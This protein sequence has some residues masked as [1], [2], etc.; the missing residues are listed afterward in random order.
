LHEQLYANEACAVN[1]RGVPFGLMK[2]APP[3]RVRDPLAAKEL[4]AAWLNLQ[5]TNRIVQGLLE[6]RLRT[7][8]DLSWPEFEVLWR[9]QLASGHPLQ[10]SEIAEQLLGSPSGITRMADRLERSGLLA[11][12]VPR[13]NRRIVQVKLT[14]QGRAV[15]ATARQAFVQALEDA[16]SAHLSPS[17][18]SGLRRVLRKL[19]QGNGAWQDARCDPGFSDPGTPEEG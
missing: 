6:Q 12:E 2:A 3:A 18:V 5:Q 10:M 7:E 16:F 19:L 8:T 15:L 13:E 4:I 1:L 14:E 17:D 11:R 9:I